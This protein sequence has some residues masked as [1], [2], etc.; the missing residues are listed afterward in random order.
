[1]APIRSIA[2]L[3]C[4]GALA[5][6]DLPNVTQVP[7]TLLAGPI[8]PEQGRAAIVAWHGGRIV[9]V[10][11]APGSQPGADL[12]VRVVDIRDP[13]SPVVEVRPFTASGFNAHGYFHS[14]THLYIGPHT[15]PGGWPDSLAITPGG[16]VSR[17]IETDLGLPVGTYNRS[18]AQ[19]PWGAEMWWSYGAVEGRAFLARRRSTSHWVHDWANGGAPTGPAVTA[20]WDH[21]GRT[22]VVGQPF[23]YGNILIYA[24]DQTGTGVATYDISDPTNPVLLDVLKEGNPGGYWPEV[25]GH[26]LFFPRRDGEG[27]PGSR[28][29]FMIVDF[30]DPT[31][32]RVVANRNLEGSN[33]YVTFQDEFAFMNH[34]KI[35]LRTFEPVLTLATNDTT[36]DASQFAL[37]VGNLVVTGGYGSLGPGLAIWAH[38]AAPDTRGPFVAWHLPRPDQTGYSTRCPITLSIPETLR[39]ETIVDGTT[40]IL[41]PLTG[42]GAGIAVPTWHAFGQNKLLTVTPREDLRPDTTYEVVLTSGIQDAVGNGME[43]Y[44]FRFSTGGTLGAGNR[45]PA[46]A[47]LTAA[48]VPAAVGATIALTASASD[49]DGDAL[50]FRFDF[51][52]G[53]P[54]TGWFAA[55]TAAHAYAAAGH[56]RVAVQARDPS[57]AIATRTVQVTVAPAP[58]GPAPRASG[59]L[60]LAGR[61]LVTVNP[62]GDT[63]TA[64]DA[65]TRARLW[66]VTVGADPRSVTEAGDGTLWVACHDA[67]RIDILAATTGALLA[68]LPTG[69]G[70]APVAVLAGPGGVVYGTTTGDGRLRRWSVAGRSETGRLELGPTAR[71]IALTGDGTRALITRFISGPHEGTVWDVDLVGAMTLT[72]TIRLAREWVR[73]GSASG[74][75]VPNY[76]AGITIDPFHHHAWVVGK[77]DNTDRGTYLASALPLGQDNTVRADLR[78]IDL[79]T[80]TEAVDL[81]LDIDNSD[82]P[83][84]VAFSPRGDWAFIAQQGINQVAVIDRLDFL[85]ADSAKGAIT[86]FATGLA[87]QGLLLDPATATLWSQDFLGR[88]LTARD[89]SGFLAAG[90]LD[91]PAATV[92]AQVTE[93]L[94][95]EVLSGKRI[96][97]N[98]GDRRMS[99]EGYISCASCHVDGGHDGRTWDFT[100]RGE[101]FRN[102]TD[103]RGRAGTGHGR[104]HWSANFDEIQDFENDIRNDFGG[105]GFL[106][107]ADFAASATTLGVAKAGRSADL[108]ALAAYVRS[109]GN[110]SL[111]VSP[112]RAADGSRTATGA[113]G[114]AIFAREGCAD[115]HA[116]ATGFTDR[117][118]HDVGTLRASSGRRLGATLTGIDTPTLLGV[119]A[120]APY[121]H[122]G[123]AATLDEVF[124]VAGG[125]TIQAEDGVLGSGAEA[126]DPEWEPM[127]VWRGRMVHLDQGEQVS[128]P[129]IAGGAG[130]A[131]AVELRYSVNYGNGSITLAA[132]GGATAVALAVLPNDPGWMQNEWRRVRIPVRLAPGANTITVTRGA[133]GQVTLDEITVSTP[134]DLARAA[135]HRRV[136][137]LPAGERAD[138]LA[139]L[140]ELDATEAPADATPPRILSLAAVPRPD[141][142][143]A[144]LTA[145][146]DDPG[147]GAGL[148]WHWSVAA[149]PAGGAAGFS[150]SGTVEAATAVATMDRAGTWTLRAELRDGVGL[151]DSAEVMV[152]LA[153]TPTGLVIDPAVAALVPAGSV[154]FA[155]LLRDPF[156]ALVPASAAWGLSGVGS[157]DADGLYRA[158]GVTGTAAISATAAGFTATAAITI[159]LAPPPAPGGGGG[160]GGGCGA[161]ALAALLAGLGLL[162]AR[163]R[164]G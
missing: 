54:R 40:L 62:D 131:G 134:A 156:G 94:A 93:R 142:R 108:D 150:R 61:R 162:L 16:L 130:G 163:R 132:G 140:R 137:A 151:A 76:L 77:K 88:T 17:S 104:V 89:L 67:D 21:L 141:G 52:D 70:S 99:A 42:T 139:H 2:V 34:Y 3:C 32:L 145:T 13:A 121:L 138:L 68:S 41:R 83:T 123:S 100:N 128:F 37:P 159:A 158:P 4:F 153:A 31:D 56:H 26:Y 80:G 5:A 91:P 112:Q 38:Q 64:V 135:P 113:R 44:A 73:D 46:V 146:G 30:S 82:S 154:R 119:H 47:G 20:T 124:T 133:G 50:V 49:P 84:A 111:P 164:T 39:T 90:E 25:Y 97:Y 58:T 86:R 15:V 161:G 144:A 136:A 98:A 75:G 122:D 85:R 8:D 160:G 95:A 109:L 102:T 107:D 69:R 155:A 12:Q 157:V 106:S 60:A 11:E 35:D 118:M 103:L 117:Q 147:G 55:A 7:G 59:P 116:P 27:G 87:P 101:G 81:R 149:S 115:C 110:A 14:G 9:S 143:T 74:R 45:P 1:M 120:G 53:S 19:S 57:G 6:A 18:G 105:R 28:A 114:A 63:V 10:P 43:S 127:K 79:A 126:G 92:A 72:R 24:A 129:G 23:I 51:G 65:D 29:G 66:E 71:A 78:C 22:G 96:F 48:P 36:L 148:T 152:T 33:Q 125:T